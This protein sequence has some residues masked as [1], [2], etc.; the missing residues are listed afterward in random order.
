MRSL[1]LS[2]LRM[3]L[4]PWNVSNS[5][6]TRRVPVA[7]VRLLILLTSHSETTVGRDCQ[8][9]DGTVVRFY[10]LPNRCSHFRRPRRI[11]LFSYII[12]SLNFVLPIRCFKYMT[13]AHLQVFIYLL[14]TD[15]E[16]LK[17]NPKIRQKVR[18]NQHRRPRNRQV[19]RAGHQSNH[20]IVLLWIASPA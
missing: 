12:A 7:N 3:S 1:S 14:K 20:N 16:I 8:K 6:R 11:Q 10:P 5:R 17:I 9:L 13:Y 2:R 4:V 18:F 15:R 19:R